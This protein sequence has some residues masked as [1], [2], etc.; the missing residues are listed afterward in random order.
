MFDLSR[1]VP[2]ARSIVKA[3]ADIY[4]RHTQPWFVGL[5]AHGSALKGDFIP[6][7]SDIDFQLFLDEQ[8]FR[9]PYEL[10]FETCLAIQQDLAQIDPSPFRYIQG[11]AFSDVLP[12]EHTGPVPGAYLLLA[13]K[14]PVA[15]ATKDQLQESARIRIA[16]LNPLPPYLV[17]SLLE[18]G[19]GRLAWHIRWLCTDVWPTAYQV[20]V[21]QGY[22]PFFIWSLPKSQAIALFPPETPLGQTSRAFYQA[23]QTYY[24][25][26]QVVGEG[27]TV[28]RTGVAFLYAVASWWQEQEYEHESLTH[29][30]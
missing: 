24:P 18:H 27:L 3:A 5:V 11:K 29:D 1:L 9:V 20:L 22:D 26:G 8:A 17:G 30:Q 14:L 23:V 13:G 15:E 6:G 12:S 19:K 28:I 25:S 10:P 7:C 2:E 21:L 4:L 16:T